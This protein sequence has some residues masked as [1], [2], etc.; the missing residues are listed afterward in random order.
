MTP[1][2]VNNAQCRRRYVERGLQAADQ[3][4]ICTRPLGTAA[5]RRTAPVSLTG[6]PITRVLLLLEAVPC[7]I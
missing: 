6:C 5:V 1:G 3:A 4:T 7:I 2:P